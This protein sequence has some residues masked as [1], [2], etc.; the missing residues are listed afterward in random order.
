MSEIRRHPQQRFNLRA[1]LY[2]WMGSA[3]A[4]L[5]VASLTGWFITMAFSIAN[6]DH[7]LIRDTII[8]ASNGSIQASQGQHYV[9]RT[10]P[11]F[12]NRSVDLPG[13][14]YRCTWLGV[15]V[16]KRNV[17]VSL[18]LVSMVMLLPAGLCLHRYQAA[19]SRAKLAHL[20]D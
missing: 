8:S 20:K 13:F 10:P 3:C 19:K 16:V 18:F 12:I 5:V 15:K 4:L 17:R 6:S 11:L 9:I 14:S 2:G 1:S 7:L